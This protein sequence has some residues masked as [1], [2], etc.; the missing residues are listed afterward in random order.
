M[1]VAEPD[2][3]LILWFTR[4]LRLADHPALDYAVRGGRPLIACYVLDEHGP[5]APGGASRWWLHGSLEALQAS[6]AKLGGRLILRRGP[7]PTALAKLAAE[8]DAGELVCSR[9]YEPQAE[10][11]ERAV[12]ALLGA[13]G[14]AFKACRGR[15]LFEPGAVRT[16]SGAP[17][18][19]FAPFWRNCVASFEA[20]QLLRPPT[21]IR[22][23]A[24]PPAGEP[25]AAWRLRPTAPDWAAGFGARWT[26]GEAHAL[27]S[28]DRF[29]ERG[30]ADYGRLRD[31]PA[32]AATSRLSP[33]LHFGEVSPRQVWAVVASRAAVDASASAGA[34]AYLRELGWREFA[35][36]LLAQRP[37]LPT[38]PFNAKFAQFP[39]RDDDAL[40]A[41]WQRGRT[42]YPIVDAGMR[43][44]WQTGWMHNRVRMIAASFLVKHLLIRWQRGAAWFWD[45][46][47]DAD[48]ANN[49]AGWQWVAGSG[50]DAAPYFRIFNPTLQGKKFDPSGDYVR[51]WV[52]EL[53]GLPDALIHEPWAGSA[54]ALRRTGV[55][56]DRSYP[57]PLV[58]HAFARRRALAAYAQIQAVGRA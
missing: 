58:E 26:A 49:S 12:E 45:T 16:Q 41:A 46:L 6:L 28:V 3:P 1:S 33:H 39:W 27:R 9:R 56:L 24:D 7:A 5:A 17:F 25:L 30:L 57:R 21:A 19:V 20:S 18:K 40:L 44:L 31:R 47:V 13:R 55:E 32:L 35:F 11:E 38:A 8:A 4:D 37:D 23:H 42:G 43:E 50:A 14:V 34:A 15:L 53:A 54:A 51:R 22:F 52:P 48:L 36:H 10:R 29:V 2:R